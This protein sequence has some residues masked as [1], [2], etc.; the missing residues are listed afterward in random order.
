MRYA[1]K[2]DQ[3]QQAIVEALRKVGATVEPLFRVGGGCPDLL[4]GYRGVNY[5]IEVKTPREGVLTEY[6][7][8]WLA[9]WAGTAKVCETVESA[10]K[11][12]GVEVNNAH[13]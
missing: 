2:V 3:S 4:I 7:T 5:L 10:L 12:I 8:A 13:D 6:Q 1:A 9:R 11:I